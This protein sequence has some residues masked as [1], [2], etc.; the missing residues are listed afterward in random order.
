MG[1]CSQKELP[2]DRKSNPQKP[3]P[4]MTLEQRIAN[5]KFKHRL[6]EMCERVGHSRGDEITEWMQQTYKDTY[7]SSTTMLNGTK[8]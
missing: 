7:H 1:I 4:G 5:S 2:D 6:Y 3:K 8:S